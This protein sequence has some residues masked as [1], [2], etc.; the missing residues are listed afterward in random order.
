MYFHKI[1]AGLVII[2]IALVVVDMAAEFL[3]PPVEDEEPISLNSSFSNQVTLMGGDVLR[4]DFTVDNDTVNFFICDEENYDKYKESRDYRNIETHELL[5]NVSK[6]DFKFTT[7]EGDS[8]FETESWHVV[9]DTH[10]SSK[11]ESVVD[12][13]IEYEAYRTVIYYTK[14]IL[15]IFGSIR[16]LQGL[17][18][19]KKPSEQ[20]D[21]LSPEPNEIPTQ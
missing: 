14:I 20:T 7:P 8:F 19:K 18:P 10:N 11:S 5:E 2:V 21:T 17:R 3:N 4:G 16:I 1:F 15:L 6:G 9:F 12:F 13:N